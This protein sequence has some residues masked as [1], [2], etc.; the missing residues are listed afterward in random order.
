MSPG[1]PAGI[2]GGRG[3]AA[4]RRRAPQ[5][6]GSR[7]DPP[8][9][10]GPPANVPSDP[11][12]LQLQLEYLKETYGNLPVYVQENGMGSADDGLDDTERV[13]YLSSY[14]E[15]ALNAMRNGADVRGYFAWAFM[16]LFE[17]LSGYQSRYGLY[18][19][20]FADERRPRQASLSARWYSGFLKHNGTTPLVSTPSVPKYKTF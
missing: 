18:R 17:L 5:L 6:P 13:S 19:V 12:G 11:K 7:I 16:E 14:M 15:S 2:K 4:R 10:Q 1:E 8:S 3:D 20:D 9:S